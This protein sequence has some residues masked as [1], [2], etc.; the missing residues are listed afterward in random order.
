MMGTMTHVLAEIMVWTT[1]IREV[2]IIVLV[3][4]MI[5][6]S[7]GEPRKI[8]M[9]VRVVVPSGIDAELSQEIAMNAQPCKDVQEE[10]S[11]LE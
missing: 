3:E 11:Q 6:M 9:N 5:T 7:A 1:V 2:K 8:P 4:K 10:T